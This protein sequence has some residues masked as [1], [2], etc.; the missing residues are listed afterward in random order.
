MLNDGR[1]EARAREILAAHSD[2]MTQIPTAVPQMLVALD[3]AQASPAQA[4]VAGDPKSPEVSKGLAQLHH[5][6]HPRRVILSATSDGL[7]A[8]N[9]SALAA[10][11]PLD[12]APALY[13]CENFTCQRPRAL[14]RE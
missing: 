13:L 7:P 6:F 10:M 12:G 3:F 4:V 9:N 8:K 11:K 5:D 14:R 2:Q 1:R